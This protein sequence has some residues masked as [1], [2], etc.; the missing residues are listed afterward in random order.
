M[1]KN[2]ETILVEKFGDPL[3][4]SRSEMRFVCPKCNHKS[5]HASLELGIF[6]CFICTYGAGEA[7]LIKAKQQTHFAV[8]EAA[9]KEVLNWLVNNLTLSAPHRK[10]LKSRGVYNPEEFK[11]SS[12]PYRLEILLNSHFSTEYLLSSGFFR[13]SVKSGITGWPALKPDRIFMPYWVEE[14]VIGCKTRLDPYHFGND[15]CKYAIPNGSRIGKHLW[16]PRPLEG[17]VI[18]TE[19]EIKAA[20]ACQLNIT[21]C[22]T[23]G[24]NGAQ[25]ALTYLPKY[26]RKGKIKRLFIIYDNEITDLPVS[27]SQIQAQKLAN[28]I[29]NSVN[30]LLPLNPNQKKID[31][32]AFIIEQGES[33]LLDLMEDAWYEKY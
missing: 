23:S 22:S 3:K 12:I 9:N 26:V 15:E 27:L 21:A 18:L 30:V 20:A 14:N 32:D 4:V 16:C 5:L 2:L 25:A 31:L 10:F 6:Y 7:P 28:I 17:D 13:Q 33:R 24:I 8:N 19:G 1:G 29:P 11:F